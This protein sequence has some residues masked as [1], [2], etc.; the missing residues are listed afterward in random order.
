MKRSLVFTILFLASFALAGCGLQ[1]AWKG[2]SGT[3]EKHERIT[4]D[5]GGSSSK[6]GL[7]DCKDN[8]ALAGSAPKAPANAT[9]PPPMYGSRD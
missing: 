2:P 7:G 4:I 9:T 6:S 1:S 8:P 3:Y 5:G